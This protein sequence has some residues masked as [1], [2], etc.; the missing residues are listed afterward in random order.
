MWLK[1]LS[2]EEKYIYDLELKSSGLDEGE[3]IKRRDSHIKKLK[4]FRKSQISKHN[5]R[6]NKWQYL[7]G[8]RRFHKSTS[9]KLFHRELGRFLANRTLS[10]ILYSESK[11]LIKPIVSSLVHSY[12]EY[13]YFMS[14][15]EQID[16]NI[17]VEYLHDEITNLL[18]QVRKEN[19]DL[20]KYSEFLYRLV[21]SKELMKSFADK[22]GLS[23]KEI[24]DMWDSV[25][26]SLLDQGKKET[27]DNFYSLLVG[28][29]KKNLKID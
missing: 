13:E 23:I 12:I 10:G 26:Q 21:E 19:S 9:G 17:F 4:D 5:W 1:F 14:L 8:I 7:K 22:S 15:D 18:I 29:L 20:S 6:T 25:K 24:E 2:E 27:D 3:F 11:D 28:I 16:Y